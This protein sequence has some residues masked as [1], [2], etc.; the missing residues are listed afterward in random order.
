MSQPTSPGQ[1]IDPLTTRRPSV[2]LA[3][4][5]RQNSSTASEKLQEAGLDRRAQGHHHAGARSMVVKRKQL[6]WLAKKEGKDCGVGKGVSAEAGGV[7]LAG[8]AQNGQ[9]SS[10]LLKQSD[11]GK[12]QGAPSPLSPV[13]TASLNGKGDPQ[14]SDKAVS[15]SAKRPSIASLGHDMSVRAVG[16]TRSMGQ[17]EK[18]VRPQ[19]SLSLGAE[20]RP[21]VKPLRSKHQ[22]KQ[23]FGLERAK[24]ADLDDYTPSEYSTTVSSSDVEHPPILSTVPV[25]PPVSSSRI[26]HQPIPRR[27]IDL[28]HY[29]R[30]VQKA[31]D[32][33]E[34][35]S[36]NELGPSLKQQWVKGRPPPSNAELAPGAVK[37][38]CKTTDS[39]CECSTTTVQAREEGKAN[40]AKTIPQK[41]ASVS[42]PGEM[43]RPVKPRLTRAVQRPSDQ[44]STALQSHDKTQQAG[45]AST[46]SDVPQHVDGNNSRKKTLHEMPAHL[47]ESSSHSTDVPSHLVTSTDVSN[48]PLNISP[49]NTV[50]P[51]PV[52]RHPPPIATRSRDLR[53]ET[54][55]MDTAIRDHEKLMGKA[56][57]AAEEAAGRGHS[58]EVARILEGAS[59]A[60]HNASTT[61]LY[62]RSTAHHIDSPLQLSPSE[63][64][65]S[66]DGEL[67]DEHDLWNLQHSR[68][69]STETAPTLVTAQS[70]KSP[71]LA[72]PYTKDGKQP[73]PRRASMHSGSSAEDV[74]I[75][76]TPPGLYQ[77]PSVESIVKDFAYTDIQ[78]AKARSLA[79]LAGKKSLGAAAD[80]Y[81]DQGESVAYQPGVRKS[82]NPSLHDLPAEE[83]PSSGHRPDRHKPGKPARPLPKTNAKQIELRELEHVPTA[84]EPPKLAVDDNVTPN[85]TRHPHRRGKNHPHVSDF[86]E[87]SYYR[88]PNV[89]PTEAARKLSSVTD[90]RSVPKAPPPHPPDPPLP[91]RER[92]RRPDEEEEEEEDEN[93]A[94]HVRKHI[95]LREGQGFSLGRYHRR[96]PIARE[97]H[98]VRKRIAATVACFNTVFIGLIAGI[99]AGEVPKMQFQIADVSHRV[100]MGNVLLFCGLGLTTFIFWPLPLLHG[101]KPYTLLA[102]ALMLP[103]Q[104]P[105]AIAVSGNQSRPDSTITR[106]GLLVPRIF[107]GI[108]LGFANINQ[109]PTLL[110]LFGS[111]LMSEA[112]H[113]EFVN[114]DDVRRQGGG[115]GIWLGI[116]SFCFVGSLSI[117]FCIG[118]CII[119]GLDPSWGFYIIVILLAFFLL[120]NVIIPETRR[121]PYRRSIAHFFDDDDR[122]RR[123]VA[124]GEV[125]L[126]ISNDGPKW[127]FQEVWAG[128]VLSKRMIGQPGFFVLGSY[129]GW[130]YAQV[131]LVILFLGALLSRDYTWQ[132]QY[133]GLA[134][135]S[136]AIGAFFAMPLAKASI[137]SRARFTPQPLAFALTA[138]GESI[139]WTAPVLFTGLIGFLSCLAMAECVGLIMETFDTCDLQPGVNSK[140]RLNSMAE[141]TRRRRTN[142]SSFPRV[143][144]GFFAAQSLGFF[145]A[146]AATGVSGDITRALG[147]QVAVSIVAAILL[148]VTLLFMFIMW[149][150]REVQVIPNSV[151]GAATRK[152]S[153][154]WNNNAG[155][156]GGA[157][158]DDAD[159]KA[160][161]IG[162]PSQKMRRINLLEMGGQTRW[163]E[164]RK[165]NRLMG[166]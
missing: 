56:F 92:T 48:S 16:S 115:V 85:G 65:L 156:G 83:A 139:S 21:G 160:V 134:S 42:H 35:M 119:A 137:F 132:S 150:W 131:T 112:P 111:S 58:N 107:T 78:S 27:Q 136:L 113:Q 128:L 30:Q 164:I 80:F 157:T 127:W 74:S 77:P 61:T 9:G 8:S 130:I 53:R 87:S 38:K 15:S 1:V 33:K 34:H 101:R 123:R 52:P 116:W 57:G 147:A 44:T 124:R 98:P 41:A 166:R 97:W 71:L 163:T 24:K 5:S 11:L 110:D 143:C 19:R 133:V 125:K 10:G 105:Q 102:F 141:T 135:L 60:L 26:V 91:L 88:H 75:A 151:F 37:R 4:P 40:L 104:F 12:S 114:N 2:G 152:G 70:S 50:K 76:P 73:M 86:F 94:K 126:H 59:S 51:P 144:A 55:K 43:G 81:N 159:W 14:A 100:L 23:A 25:T 36:R 89:N 79:S 45:V 140:H 22:A 54:R 6:P 66:T 84:S 68:E 165:L 46:G 82:M 90:T 31:A 62:R 32:R 162:N 153:T 129:I 69:H 103:L 161:V 63:S 158:G 138:S 64:G 106:V 108:A 67:S 28:T 155:G 72:A 120:V 3:K 154:A 109:L 122:L 146:A 118:A 145:L 20:L 39:D 7:E 47:M 149:R 18:Q 142:Y 13:G 95:S 49:K 96:Q 93:Y 121:A 117:G 29:Q 17:G 148:F 99:Y